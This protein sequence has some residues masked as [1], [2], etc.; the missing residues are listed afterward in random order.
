VDDYLGMC[1]VNA[2]GP[3]KRPEPLYSLTVHCDSSGGVENSARMTS[4]SDSQ[5]IIESKQNVTI[6]VPRNISSKEMLLKPFYFE[7]EPVL[8]STVTKNRTFEE[9]GPSY[10]FPH[11]T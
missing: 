6:S 8:L 5:L 1:C 2:L 7:N 11:T 10:L 4:I 9:T 3:C